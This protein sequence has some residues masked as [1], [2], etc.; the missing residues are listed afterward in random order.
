VFDIFQKVISMQIQ[1]IRNLQEWDSL[2]EEW[3]RLLA[4]GISNVPFLRHEYLRAW[5]QYRGGGEWET[6]DLYIVTGRSDDGALLGIA[7]LFL[8]KNH[9]GKP[10]L[11]FIGSLEISDFLD[12]IVAPA[13]VDA[14]AEALLEH[15]TGADAPAWEA[16]TL[17]NILEDSPSLPALQAAAEAYGLRFSQE[18][19]QASPWVALPD[20]FDDYLET[21]DSRYRRELTRKMRNVLGYFI[22]T[23]VVQVD[24]TADL[25]AEMEDFFAMMRQEAHKDAFLQ[26]TM[27]EQMKAITRAA[28]EH[29][30]LDLRF[31]VVGRDKAAGYLNFVYNNRVWV[32]N[33]CMA[34]KFSSLSPG[35][36]LAGLLV[37]EAI[38]Q[39]AE[40][41]DMMRGDEEYKY[42]LGGTDRW[43]SRAQ[44]LK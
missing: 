44:V 32:Y 29:G 22:P 9:A 5:W 14:F 42:Q 24:G 33:S 3:N 26:G 39:G 13:H 28:A 34:S 35:I 25:D 10:A 40:A 37:K 6:T 18:Q 20:D 43:V 1:V 4:E 2:A 21:L 8:S 12:L 11:F 15:L 36:A 38:E 41:F 30:W 16:L 27:P 17:D 31:L 7:P 23:Q 19:L